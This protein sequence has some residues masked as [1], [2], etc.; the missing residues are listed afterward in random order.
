[1]W[2]GLHAPR[3][4]ELQRR[5]PAAGDEHVRRV[6]GRGHDTSSYSAAACVGSN[7]SANIVD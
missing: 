5:D 4:Q 3:E 1:V 7:L 2:P 6:A